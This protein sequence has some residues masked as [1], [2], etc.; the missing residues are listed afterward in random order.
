MGFNGGLNV[1]TNAAVAVKNEVLHLV[2]LETINEM[3]FGNP[4][5]TKPRSLINQKMLHI[6]PISIGKS[7]SRRTRSPP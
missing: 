1:K 5:K 3:M 4:Y 2:I 6:A 7:I